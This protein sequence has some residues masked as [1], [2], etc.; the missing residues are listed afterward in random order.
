MR[1]CVCL[2]YLRSMYT[3]PILL[4]LL[5]I[6]D[7]MYDLTRANETDEQGWPLSSCYISL[8]GTPTFQQL[9]IL[10]SELGP[11]LVVEDNRVVR[12]HPFGFGQSR[13]AN[14]MMQG[15]VKV[16]VDMGSMEESVIAYGDEHD[17]HPYEPEPMIP[18]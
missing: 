2:G 11:A 1:A 3:Q 10:H 4:P 14:E 17:E 13:Q 9:L 16:A 6:S 12:K 8:P 15:R 7:F 5:L 18:F